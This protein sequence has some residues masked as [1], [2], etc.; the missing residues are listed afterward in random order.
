MLAR[1]C[2]RQNPSY[3]SQLRQK[4]D[5]RDACKCINEVF[6]VACVWLRCALCPCAAL[7]EG[8][9]EDGEEAEE[10]ARAREPKRKT[11]RPPGYKRPPAK[12]HAA[13]GEAEGEEEEEEVVVRPAPK[14]RR[15]ST[16]ADGVLI[17]AE[18]TVTVRQ[19]TRARVEA[20]EE[21]RKLQEAVRGVMPACQLACLRLLCVM[22]F[23]IRTHLEECILPEAAQACTALPPLILCL[24]PL[25]I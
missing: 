4:G 14:K 23:R 1:L 8:E 2:R 11:L 16:E 18:R 13:A 17:P 15:T 25:A 5:R 6:L 20:A 22:A 21:E 24:K 12:A 19:S 3:G 9:E 10:D 7:Q